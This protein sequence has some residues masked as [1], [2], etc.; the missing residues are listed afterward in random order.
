MGPPE[1]P[2]GGNNGGGKA[3]ISDP[4]PVALAAIP[5]G[6]EIVFHQDGFIYVMDS[7]GGSVT[8]ITLENPRNYHHAVVSFD[9][10]YVAANQS[11]ESS[12]EPGGNSILWI[13]DLQNGTEARLV[14]KFKTAGNGGV[15]WDRDGLIY[16]AAKEKDVV[17][18]PRTVD[19]F[20][21]NAAAN[22]VYRIRFD[23]TGLERL[24]M[25]TD[26]GESDVSV[27]SDGSLVAFN[28]TFLDPPNDVMEIWVANADG[29][30]PQLV[31]IGGK[32]A[33]EGVFDP[34][35]ILSTPNDKVVF[36][37]VNPNVL[38]NFPNSANTAHD[39]WVKDA[40]GTPNTTGARITD[41]GPISI[42]P[43]WREDDLIVYT[44]L[45]DQD[46]DG[47]G[48]EDYLGT[49]LV[50]TDGTLVVPARIRFGASNAAWIPLDQIPPRDCTIL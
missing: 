49:S 26:R 5:V 48:V 17:K 33:E 12:G 31:F 35:I 39:L 32:P 19:D 28:A 22:D 34:S 13:F 15:D 41:P 46:P 14:P 21:A 37:Q 27:S 10:R 25:T 3:A 47:Q 50:N 30:N 1:E 8:Q 36:S 11:L 23:G 2:G 4:E 45:D 38:P 44:E 29:T 9:H 24:V 16:F 7:C 42:I 20:I 43:D 18:K 40:N 6:A